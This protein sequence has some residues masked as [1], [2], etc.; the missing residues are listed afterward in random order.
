LLNSERALYALGIAAYNLPGPDADNF[1]SLIF[2]GMLHRAMKFQDLALVEVASAT[3]LGRG[4]VQRH[5]AFEKDALTKPAG[6]GALFANGSGHDSDFLVR[7][8]NDENAA[9]LPVRAW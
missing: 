8:T 4:P 5:I 2:A 9:F 7:G 1:E 3:F 6:F